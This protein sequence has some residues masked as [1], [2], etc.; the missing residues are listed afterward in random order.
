L[1]GETRGSLFSTI[2]RTVTG[3]GARELA[4]R[5]SAP[6][7]D[8]AAINARLDAVEWFLEARDLRARLR[9][10]LRAAPDMARALSRLSLGRGG[11]RDLAAI[12]DGL[13]A[14]HAIASFLDDAAGASSQDILLPLPAALGEALAALRSAGASLCDRLSAALA[15]DLPLVARDGGFI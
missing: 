10:R 7:T 12:R 3:A 11:P 1:K 8:P 14:G 2:D 4:S 5:L 13:G 15:P 6:L 9:A